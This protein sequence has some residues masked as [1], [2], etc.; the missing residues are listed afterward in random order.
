MN[1][2]YVSQ[3]ALASLS[4]AAVNV[5]G[6][7]HLGDI[8][9]IANLDV[10]GSGPGGYILNFTT[11][12]NITS[13]DGTVYHNLALGN[14]IIDFENNHGGAGDISTGTV[15]GNGLQTGA[16]FHSNGGVYFNGDIVIPGRDLNL[17]C[18]SFY[19][20]GQLNV[21]P[22]NI[23]S[24]LP[25]PTVVLYTLGGPGGTGSF[26][27]TDY[28]LSSMTADTVTI[29][30]NYQL[31]VDAALGN[32]I[33]GLPYLLIAGGDTLYLMGYTADDNVSPFFNN[34]VP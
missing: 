11:N 30:N 15:T 29:G 5:G 27:L 13:F 2:L 23:V 8:N 4:A 12:G 19:A 25:G 34:I 18:S 26:E 10:S 33:I 24:I 21:G 31:G 16:I 1:T 3:N 7:G 9:V 28:E 17:I 22:G 14:R 32:N 20:A 6:D